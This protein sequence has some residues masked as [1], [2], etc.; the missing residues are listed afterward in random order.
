MD[1]H[2]DTRIIY[3]RQY[4][5]APRCARKT[6]IAVT[7]IVYK[8]MEDSFQANMCKQKVKGTTVKITNLRVVYLTLYLPVMT[9][10][11]RDPVN[12]PFFFRET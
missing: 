6:I 12:V 9:F 3:P 5:L 7:M 8:V 10:I 4:K 2:L 11:D 1:I